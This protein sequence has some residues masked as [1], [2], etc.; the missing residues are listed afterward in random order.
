MKLQTGLKE[1]AAS[2]IS[3]KSEFGLRGAYAHSE[4]SV[5][6]EIASGRDKDLADVKQLK[7]IAA[8]SK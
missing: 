4:I 2:S 7:A 1:F 6:G 5:D 8:K 3:H